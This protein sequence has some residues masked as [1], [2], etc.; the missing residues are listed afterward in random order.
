VLLE[1]DIRGFAVAEHVRV[2]FA[3]GLNVITGETGAGKSIIVGA[4]GMLLGGRADATDVRAGSESARVEG[5]FQIR[6]ESIGDELANALSEAGVEIEDDTLIVS[7][8]LWISGRA[9][10]TARINGRAVLQSALAALGRRLVD[11]HSQTDH[12]ALLQPAEHIRYLDR[13]AGTDAERAAFAASAHRLRE[14]RGQL[15]RLLSDDRERAR[16]QD[17][18]RHECDE[19][20]AARI[21][22]D[23]EDD[24][25]VERQLLENS[26]QLVTLSEA[27]YAALQGDVRATGAVD[28]LGQAAASVQTLSEFDPRLSE[29]AATAAALQDQAADLGREI[30]SY[31][32]NVEYNPGRLEAIED[33]LSLLMTLKRKYGAT[34]PEVIAYGESAAAELAELAGGEEQRD[35][36]RDEESVLVAQLGQM[37]A[38]LGSKREAAAARLVE[39]LDAQFADLKMSAAR[40][41]VSFT[42]RPSPEGIPASLTQETV[43]GDP[44]PFP[45][46]VA[47]SH[48][49]SDASGVDRIE[50]LVTLNPG[51]PLRPLAR[52]ASGGETSRLMLALKT[53]LGDA[54]AVPV[55]VFDEIEAGL[56]GR[57][58][59]IVGEKLA[60][61]SEHHQV[62]CVSHLPQIA[63][64]ADR[65]LTVT[66]RVDAGRTGVEIREL[67]PEERVQE[68]AAM[69]GSV[70]ESTLA[71]ARELLHG[72][73]A[74][75]DFPRK[76]SRTP[77][78]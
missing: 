74:V 75:P 2:A 3:P 36:L 32:E 40:F 50:F 30:R 73:G 31:R 39:L 34:I 70:T 1:L 58:G 66:K 45:K 11:I 38:A 20:E 72:N 49:Q 63:A 71:S 23:E 43:I 6:A 8:D 28:A 41:A 68:L 48:F 57:S 76:K 22:P 69:L 12:V 78:T 59:A 33:R 13:F 37:A 67:R 18:L 64:R 25:R 42:R 62:I 5:I 47:D 77:V 44:S 7:R 51:E 60:R 21:L 9:R 14:V 52:V 16:R 26:E 65:H 56:G 55:L 17:R 10:T 24:L 29:L 19:I 61:L 46:P 35:R 27:A 4:L 15:A 54:D 53:V